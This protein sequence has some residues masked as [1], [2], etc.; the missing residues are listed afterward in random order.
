M[1]GQIAPQAVARAE[2]KKVGDPFDESTEQGP[3]ISKGQFDKILDYVKKGQE[4]G[5]PWHS[6]AIIFC[7]FFASYGL[8]GC[9]TLFT[10]ALSMAP[11][12]QGVNKRNPLTMSRTARRKESSQLCTGI[13]TF[14][15]A[16]ANLGS[17]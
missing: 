13:F 14:P 10:R 4:E 16:M 3:Q 8:K 9:E 2:K 17:A 15:S 11:R 5:V 7:I 12:S 6:P 1:S